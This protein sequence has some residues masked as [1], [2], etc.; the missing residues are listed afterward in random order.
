MA[1]GSQPSQGN[2][3]QTLTTLALSLRDLA[4]QIVDQRTYLNKL[5]TSGLE[6]IGFT[7]S[8]ASTV[9]QQIDYLGTVADLYHGTATQ[10]TAF[11]FEDALTSLWAG[12]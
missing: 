1:V 5:G 8:D 3:N 10:A 11:N 7:A 9:L 6:G 2:I 12:Q 4:N